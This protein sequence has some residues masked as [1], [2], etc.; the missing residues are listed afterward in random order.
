M[1]GSASDRHSP[2]EFM[3]CFDQVC[4][5]LLVIA[6]AIIG[7]RHWAEDVVQE[8]AL[9]AWQKYDE[10]DPQTDFAAWT[11]QIT[12]N[13]AR[14]RRDHERR[15]QGTDIEQVM[16]TM[17]APP[18]AANPSAAAM[19]GSGLLDL[20]LD[21]Q[22]TAALGSLGEMPR[23]CFLLRVVLDYSYKEIAECLDIPAGTAMSHVHRTRQHLAGLL[24][25]PAAEKP[26][27][28]QV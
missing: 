11:S 10:F 9:V 5:R 27:A 15:R 12:R 24:N 25:A 16:F 23:T 19:P 8:A 13:I 26:S 7:D 4:P 17:A 21:D 1:F 28:P 14:R 22:M 2:A 6:W 3:S 18:G 20:G